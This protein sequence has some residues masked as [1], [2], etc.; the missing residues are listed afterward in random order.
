[1]SEKEENSQIKAEGK[2]IRNKKVVIQ[3]TQEIKKVKSHKNSNDSNKHHH[4]HSS[5]QQIENPQKKESKHAHSHQ[6]G[7]THIEKHIIQTENKFSENSKK[8]TKAK[9]D[10][11]KWSSF[12][13]KMIDMLLTCLPESAIPTAPQKNKMVAIETL[14]KAVCQLVQHPTENP[15][16]RELEKK[17]NKCKYQVK[18]MRRQCRDLHVEVQKNQQLLREHMMSIRE[19]EETEVEKKLQHLESIITEQYKQQAQFGLFEKLDHYD[20]IG[21]FN[22]NTSKINTLK[23]SSASKSKINR[24]ATPINSSVN[25]MNNSKLNSSNKKVVSTKVVRTSK[26]IVSEKPTKKKPT[27]I[28]E[29]EEETDDSSSEYDGE[30]INESEIEE[31]TNE[32]SE[33]DEVEATTDGEEEEN[34]LISSDESVGDNGDG[35]ETEEEEEIVPTKQTSHMKSNH[36]KRKSEKKS[37]K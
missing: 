28:I 18:N 22:Q 11:K 13:D 32:I 30:E 2:K 4:S 37:V 33:E 3:T 8:L 36:S 29:E 14:C 12:G 16:Y 26:H 9:S 6:S 23:T 34:V 25:S 35:N 19:R 10:L 21:A 31:S 24:N 27:I 7:N 20:Q 5:K 15:K 1:M 17:Y